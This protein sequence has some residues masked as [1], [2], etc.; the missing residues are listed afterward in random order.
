MLVYLG[1]SALSFQ[2]A[3]ALGLCVL[4]VIG[5]V[6]L[7]RR[8]WRLAGLIVGLP[9]VYLLYFSSQRVMTVR[10]LQVL[11]PQLALL[12]AAGAHSVL[13]AL[14]PPA[15]KGLALAALGLALAWNAWWLVQADAS[16]VRRRSIDRTAEIT[17][18]VRNSPSPVFLGSGLREE[19][20][21]E[22]VQ[23]LVD[24]GLVTLDVAQ[25]DEAIV[26]VPDVPLS[27]PGAKE[28][29]IANRPG[30]YGVLPSGPWEVNWDYYPSWSGDRRPIIISS[31]YYR[32]L[33]GLP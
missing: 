23:P 31:R 24:A 14:R 20:G 30:T 3:I 26:Y 1:V 10:N 12:A 13:G 16:I 18:Y 21:S 4:A 25:A 19:L 6:A 28:H 9:L 2:P 32:D 17:A 22:V 7:V 5:A 11:V 29:F 27:G 8:D 15:L 33:A